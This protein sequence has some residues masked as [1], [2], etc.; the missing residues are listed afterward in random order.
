MRPAMQR[1]A[2]GPRLHHHSAQRAPA[3]SNKD[4]AATLA[5]PKSTMSPSSLHGVSVSSSSQNS[6]NQNLPSQNSAPPTTPQSQSAIPVVSAAPALATVEQGWLQSPLVLSATYPFSAPTGRPVQATW[7]GVPAL[8]L[9]VT[10]D[11]S[12]TTLSGG[13]G[14]ALHALGSACSLTLAG[15]SDVQQTSY[16]ITVGATS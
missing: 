6:S 4:E 1:Q 7:T 12:T 16:T 13:S 3:T 8:T 2:S 9:S 15:P 11:G 14:L 10:C 5:T